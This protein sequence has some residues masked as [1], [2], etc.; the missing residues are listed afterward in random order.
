RI[1]IIQFYYDY[2]K[3]DLFFTYNSSLFLI[4]KM[5]YID[6]KRL[7]ALFN[8]YMRQIGDKLI[9]VLV[10]GRDGLII[11][12]LTQEKEKSE[13]EKFIGA[14]SS[15][16]EL[17]L[18]RIPKE[19]DLGTFGAGTFDTDKYRFVFC[20]AGEDSVL[21]SILDPLTLI[22]EI[23]P[24]SY[25]TAE[26]VSHI[27]EGNSNVS[28]VIPIINRETEIESLKKKMQFYQKF[29]EHHPEYVYKLSLVGD[30]GVG[31]TS[32]VQR[33]V[34]GNFSNHYKATIGTFITKKECNFDEL[35]TSVRFLIWDLAGQEQ[36]KRIWP[37]YLTDTEAGII[38]FDI[39]DQK[40][41]ENV[42]YWYDIITQVASPKLI[43]ILVGN[44]NDLNDSRVVSTKEAEN[45]AKELGIYYLET[46]AKSSD[47]INNVFEWIALQFVNEG[48]SI[49]NLS[50]TNNLAGRLNYRIEESQLIFLKQYFLKQLDYCIDKSDS[51][52]LLKY[53]ELINTIEKNKL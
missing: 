21:V 1:Q 8:W 40:S 17:I 32:I 2:K 47:N 3:D 46:S 28:P 39:T 31:K 29:K 15:L 53:L 18:K 19:F 38:V 36:F 13:E 44:K 7:L 48:Y 34:T 27:L 23:I 6:K 5:V 22:D 52:N 51:R 26:K 25:I 42:K 45:L 9:S 43:L 11:E 20:E 12:I 16:V 24:Y 41:F 4:L 30:G 10:V 35:N 33:Y 50:L 14:F 37:D 49:K